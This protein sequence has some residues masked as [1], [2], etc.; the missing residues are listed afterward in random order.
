MLKK[1]FNLKRLYKVVQ[2][3]F[4]KDYLNSLREEQITTDEKRLKT[5]SSHRVKQ[6]NKQRFIEML[7]ASQLEESKNHVHISS[8]KVHHV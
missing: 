4:S 6:L 2:E 7:R 8:T 1:W 3:M 5:K